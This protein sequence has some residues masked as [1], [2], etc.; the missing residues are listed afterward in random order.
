M[1]F[2][3]YAANLTCFGTTLDYLLTSNTAVHTH[4][5]LVRF[6][7]IRYSQYSGLR[8]LPSYSRHLASVHFASRTAGTV[9]SI[10]ITSRSLR[11]VTLNSNQVV[12]SLY[13]SVKSAGVHA[14]TVCYGLVT[15]VTPSYGQ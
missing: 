3:S 14:F 13:N 2:E 5:H 9:A 8:Y 11:S 6:L 15:S 4:Y 10:R 1:L 7:N 12:Y